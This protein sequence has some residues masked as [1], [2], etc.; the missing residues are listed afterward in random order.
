MCVLS[1]S[2]CMNKNSRVSDIIA[3]T[4]RFKQLLKNVD[5][6]ALM[7]TRAGTNAHG[8]TV[9][10]PTALL[11]NIEGVQSLNHAALLLHCWVDVS[12]RNKFT[13]N[14]NISSQFS[15]FMTKKKA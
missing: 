5:R 15:A 1:F 13:L 9:I 10:T 6:V 11:V 4:K 3:D 7:L 14:I 12:S 8:Y 2:K